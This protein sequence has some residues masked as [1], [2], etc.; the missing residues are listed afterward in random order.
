MAEQLIDKMV[1]AMVGGMT[2]KVAGLMAE[3]WIAE[4][5]GSMAER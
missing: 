5:V 4:M 2:V 3:R 1:G